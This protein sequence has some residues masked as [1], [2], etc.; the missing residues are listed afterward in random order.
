MNGRGASDLAGD[1]AGT[2]RSL[3]SPQGAARP[4]SARWAGRSAEGELAQSR[5]PHRGLELASV[6]KTAPPRPP[7]C[8][9]GP[10]WRARNSQRVL[11]PPR[12]A[13]SGARGHRASVSSWAGDEPSVASEY[14]GAFWYFRKKYDRINAVN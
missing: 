1:Y 13:E 11:P 2:S 3:P 7:R 12:S 9:L 14:R 8:E 4:V 10:A 5:P 6:G